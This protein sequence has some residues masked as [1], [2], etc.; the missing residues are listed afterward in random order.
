[1]IRAVIDTNLLV[2]YVLTN[3]AL[4][5]RIVDHWEQGTFVYLTSPQIIAELKDVLRRP[6]LRARMVA[7]PEPLIA[8][9]EADT[10]QTS[11]ALVLAGICRDPKDEIFLACAVE[12]QADYIISDDRDLLDLDAYQS[13]AIIRPAAFVAILD[14]LRQVPE[15]GA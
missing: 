14:A 1:M 8:V 9:V 12:G 2:R 4:L 13:I 5:S 7:D 10:E 6:R 3:S 11:G 15:E